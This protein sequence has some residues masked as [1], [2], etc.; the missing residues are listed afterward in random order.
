MEQKKITP[1]ERL[2]KIIENPKPTANKKTGNLLGEKKS[3]FKI[4]NLASLFK[5][6]SINKEKLKSFN[7]K[8]LNK[9]LAGFS[10]FITSIWIIDFLHV[11]MEQN[12]NFEKVI[13]HTGIQSKEALSLSSINVD[14]ND[15]YQK[16]RSRNIF[17]SAQENGKASLPDEVAQ[18]ISSLKLVG[19]LW[20]NNP[21]AMVENSAQ[22]KTFLVSAGDDIGKIKIK[23]I[24][25]DRVILLV[26]GQEQ[27][28]R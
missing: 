17:V 22:Q 27:E 28:I 18:A 1:E 11:G 16:V 15:A 23:Q 6:L 12:N 7:L 21:Q 9:S 24:M 4:K 25:R 2:L 10:V 5:G 3:L 14:V 26:D 8:S 19:I 20:S 13:K